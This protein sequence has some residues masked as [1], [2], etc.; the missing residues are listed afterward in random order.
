MTR[1]R[2]ILTFLVLAVTPGCGGISDPSST[3]V[4]LVG[5]WHYVAAQ[6]SGNRV[7]YD[8]TLVITQQSGRNFAG[9]LDAQ[10]SVPQGGVVRVNGVVSGRIVSSGSVDFDLQLSDDVRR[11]VGSI[12]RDSIT[13][14]WATSDLTALGAFTAVRIK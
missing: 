12:S 9:G 4:Q 11:H 7:M 5:N 2:A 8:G 14:S 1:F 13:G 6:T 3:D 10:A